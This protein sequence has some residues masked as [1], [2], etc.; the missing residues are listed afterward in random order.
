MPVKNK[1]IQQEDYFQGA[2]YRPRK[3]ETI[4]FK[5]DTTSYELIKG[6]NLS[7]HTGGYIEYF[8]PKGRFLLHRYLI[9]ATKGEIVDH[10]NGDRLDNRVCNLRIV[11]AQ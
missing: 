6:Y 5:I 4:Y 8:G 10:I 9:G 7:Y 1:Y 3:K 2:V 11:S